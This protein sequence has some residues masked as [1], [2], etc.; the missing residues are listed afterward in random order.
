[1]E[2]C[3]IV[4]KKGARDRRENRYNYI[5]IRYLYLLVKRKRGNKTFSVLKKL[6]LKFW[7]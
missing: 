2:K 7:I 1:M 6:S 5:K 3:T 4:K